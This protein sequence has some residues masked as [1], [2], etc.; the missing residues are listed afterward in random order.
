MTRGL[1]VRGAVVAALLGG[2][3]QTADAQESRFASDLRREGRHIAES[4]GE[5]GLNLLTGCAVTLATDY[6]F[7]LAL[8]S[9]APQNG[10][11][12]GL[13]F[14]ERFTPNERWRI[15]WNADAVGTLKSAWRA[16]AYMKIVRTPDQPGIVVR[17]PGAAPT[18]GIAIREYPVW[19]IY[20]QAVSLPRLVFAGSGVR[21][22]FSERQTIVGTS[23]VVPVG[24]FVRALRPSLIA[25]VNGRFVSIGTGR[26]PE[27]PSL[28]EVYSEDAAPGLSEQPAF[29]EF[30]EGVRLKPSVAGGRLQ[31]NYLLSY[32]QFVAAGSP[33]GSFRRWTVNL[34]H[35]IPLYRTALNA[36]AGDTNGPDECFQ[37][38]GTNTCPP[39]S[40]S[41]NLQG[42][43][44][45]RALA[46]SSSTGEG[47]QVPFYFQPT[48]GG[49]DVNGQRLLSSFDD[50]RFRGPHL[51]ALQQSVEHSLWGP[52]GVFL[53]AEQGKVSGRRS[54][55][56]FTSLARSYAAG[57]TVR[58]GGLPMMNLSFAWGDGGRHLLA[59]MDTSLLGGSGRPSLY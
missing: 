45:I 19:N 43:V 44:M 32:Q 24:G 25:A 8:G 1:A 30:Q 5:F 46:I 10:F 7:H 42:A 16:G 37:S 53:L 36:G 58:A 35:G 2:L 28:E 23:A 38:L 3:G 29:V 26:D 14:V 11:G 6:P 21:T 55:L 57:I 18:G 39:V 50:Y 12:F 34:E 15:S 17:G 4:C 47:Q 51:I 48:L 33:P 9:L 41:R 20:A 49:S 40:T 59:T 31:F 52:F 27:L 56:D 13:A 22:S 54:E